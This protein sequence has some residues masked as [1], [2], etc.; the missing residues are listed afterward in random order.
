[1]KTLSHNPMDDCIRF[2]CSMSPY[3]DGELDP[4]HAVDMEAHVLSCQPCA[5]RVALMRATRF[6]MRRTTQHRAPDA[7]RA[8]MQQVMCQERR[9]AVETRAA[10]TALQPKLIRLRYAVGLAAA[11]AVALAVG[12]ARKSQLQPSAD[13]RSLMPGDDTV[14]TAGLDSLLDD[15]VA[16]HAN[17]LPPE[18]TNPEELRRWDPLVGVPVRRPAFQPFGA[19]FS[20]ARVHAM[21]DRRAALLQYTLHN[22]HRVTVYVFNPRVM[23]M[24]GVRVLQPRVVRERPVYVGHLRG[25][26]IAAAEQSG[27]GYALATD[28]DTD[29]STRMVLAALQ[30]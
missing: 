26:S 1:M 6:S 8:R 3:V 19:S 10:D 4:A 7:L 12:M 13:Q 5:E 14:S 18:T 24:R 9:R 2:S 21:A 30:Q 11:A 15:L 17:P 29:E 25:Y 23:P 22:G 27:V 16:L 20:G 28:L